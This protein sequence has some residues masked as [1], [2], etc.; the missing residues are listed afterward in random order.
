MQIKTTTTKNKE[1]LFVKKYTPV[2]CS[3]VSLFRTCLFTFLFYTSKVYGYEIL[4]QDKSQS[5]YEGKVFGVRLN[6]NETSYCYNGIC[7]SSQLSSYACYT[8][9]DT[10]NSITIKLPGSYRAESDPCV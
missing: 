8:I 4:L 6:P 10:G 7:L 9:Q 1:Q 3:L 2:S 5:N